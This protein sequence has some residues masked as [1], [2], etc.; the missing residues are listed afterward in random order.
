MGGQDLAVIGREFAEG[1]GRIGVF[2]LYRVIG[3]GG[4]RCALAEEDAVD[5]TDGRPTP[6]DRQQTRRD[7]KLPAFREE[8][9]GIA[10]FRY[11]QEIVRDL[12]MIFA[13]RSSGL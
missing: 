13:T 7:K 8:V 11:G 4:L 3:I 1:L 6:L 5:F 9:A 12:R 2:D 10:L